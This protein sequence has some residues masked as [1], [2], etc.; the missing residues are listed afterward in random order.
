MN[1]HSRGDIRLFSVLDQE[2]R[3]VVGP[4]CALCSLRHSRI[5]IPNFRLKRF[6]RWFGFAKPHVDVIARIERPVPARRRLTSPRRP[7]AIA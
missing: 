6:F 4:L 5:E 7:L 1:S 3:A 2:L